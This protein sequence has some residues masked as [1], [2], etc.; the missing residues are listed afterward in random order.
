MKQLQLLTHANFDLM[1]KKF[2]FIGISAVAMAISLF[3]LATRGLNYGIDFRGGTTI[4]TEAT[5]PVDV[6]AYREALRR[7]WW[8]RTWPISSMKP[9]SWRHAKTNRRW[10][11]M[12]LRGPS[13]GSGPATSPSR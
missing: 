13:T 2:L 1:G 11:W 10:P 12:T 3:F 9:H 7:V 5:E 8:A 4:R 6:G